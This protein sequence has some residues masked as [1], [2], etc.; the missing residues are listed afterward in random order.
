MLHLFV[1]RN[2]LFCTINSSILSLMLVTVLYCSLSVHQVFICFIFI[3]FFCWI[4]WFYAQG[5][6]NSLNNTEL[7]KCHRLNITFNLMNLW[8]YS[9]VYP[10]LGDWSVFF[11]ITTCYRHLVKWFWFIRCLFRFL[12]IK[13]LEVYYRYE[14]KE[15]ILNVF[16]V[17]IT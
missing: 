4:R 8:I 2:W 13:L 17:M 14:M 1:E 6:M 5:F 12:V 10:V 15:E 16:Y 7:L 3:C 11:L 9:W